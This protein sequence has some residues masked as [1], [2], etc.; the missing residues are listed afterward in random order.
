ME[1]F[2]EILSARNIKIE[3]GG[4]NEKSKQRIKDAL[5]A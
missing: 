2:K 3:I 1:E 5:G 4:T